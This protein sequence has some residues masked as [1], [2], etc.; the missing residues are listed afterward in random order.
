MDVS[1]I[2][3]LMKWITEVMEE[4]ARLRQ[5]Q[6]IE[7]ILLKDVV[8]P[9]GNKMPVLLGTAVVP[10]I[11]E[12]LG[13]HWEQPDREELIFCGDFVYMTRRAYKQL[14]EYNNSVPSG[15]YE[16]KMWKSHVRY[17]DVGRV[18]WLRWFGVSDDPDKVTNNQRRIAIVKER[19]TPPIT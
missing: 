16:G 19:I 13:R 5:K 8:M 9:E 18:C 14:P 10:P 7:S 17:S 12:P 11:T 6:S 3:E 4:Q 1:T 2:I 15:V